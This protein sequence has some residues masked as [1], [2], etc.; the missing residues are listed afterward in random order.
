MGPPKGISMPLQR[1]AALALFL[2][3]LSVPAGAV[4]VDFTDGVF[5]TIVNSGINDEPVVFTETADGVTFTF[6][7]TLNLVGVERFLGIRP[8]VIGNGLHLGGGGGSTLLFTLVVD[9][10]VS[11]NSYSTDTGG[12]FLNS[13]VLDITGPG[14]SSLGNGLA[15]GNAANAFAGGPL[16]LEAGALYTFDVQNTGAAVQ[17]FVASFDVT[18]VAAPEPALAWLGLGLAALAARSRRR[19]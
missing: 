19:V 9:Q 4:P 6:E 7:S 15:Q 1:C 17:A 11:L 10:A 3:A 8:G 5:N 12:T 13:P 14:V 16:L 18:A 2:F